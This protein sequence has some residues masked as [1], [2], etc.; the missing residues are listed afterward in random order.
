M[1]VTVSMFCRE[2]GRAKLQKI[3]EGLENIAEEYSINT[4]NFCF[5]YQ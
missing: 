4:C 1:T 3:V 2:V 5:T